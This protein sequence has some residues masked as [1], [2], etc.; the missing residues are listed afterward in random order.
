MKKK[1]VWNS[2]VKESRHGKNDT[3]GKLIHQNSRKGEVISTL[4]TGSIREGY[5][6]GLIFWNWCWFWEEL[7]SA[8]CK[9]QENKG[10]LRIIF[11]C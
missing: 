5:E 7:G 9:K 3:N 11:F 6:E 10:K 4:K 2:S 8:T 1:N